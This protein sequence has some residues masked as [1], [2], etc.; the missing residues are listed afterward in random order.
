MR[1]LPKVRARPYAAQF[2]AAFGDGVFADSALAFKGVLLALE[3]F[4]QS[5][6]GIL[7]LLAASTMRTCG[8]RRR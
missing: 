4:E 2:R 8:A 1:S 3:T 6:G 7:S 5:P